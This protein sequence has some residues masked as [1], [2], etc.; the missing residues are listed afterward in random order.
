L[1]HDLVGDPLGFDLERIAWLADA[2]AGL[3]QTLDGLVAGSA[4]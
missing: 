4:L 3:H 1:A 2:E